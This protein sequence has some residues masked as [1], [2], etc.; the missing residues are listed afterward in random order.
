MQW[1][2][3][4]RKMDP[5]DSALILDVINADKERFIPSPQDTRGT[6][7][8]GQSC[9]LLHHGFQEWILAGLHGPGITT[10]HHVHGWQPRFL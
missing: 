3:C 2:W 1:Y 9:T 8:H 10:V 4:E 7:E 6:G 5:F